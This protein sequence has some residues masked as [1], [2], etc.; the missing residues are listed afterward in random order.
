LAPSLVTV[1]LDLLVNYVKLIGMSVYLTLA[2]MV[3]TVWMEWTL[4]T[5]VVPQVSLE[6][7]AQLI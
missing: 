7:I 6:K 3:G 5:A 1:F 4:T 2:T